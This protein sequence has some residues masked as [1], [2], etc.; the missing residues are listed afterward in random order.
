MEETGV[1]VSGSVGANYSSGTK[2]GEENSVGDLDF[3]ASTVAN[4]LDSLTTKD[5]SS[6]QSTTVETTTTTDKSVTKTT[7]ISSGQVQTLTL[8][9]GKCLQVFTYKTFA[10]GSGRCR[11]EIHLTATDKD[12]NVVQ[13]T[14]L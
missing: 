8:K 13:G 4:G 11:S 14:T 7:T 12:N 9:P 2:K 10:L 1:G 3:A 5:L 6:G